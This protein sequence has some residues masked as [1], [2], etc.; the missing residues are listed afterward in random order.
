MR[1]R[2]HLEQ[3]QEQ[4]LVSGWCWDESHPDRAVGLVILVDGEPVGTTV[5][6]MFRADLEQA[7]IGN[8][9]HAFTYLLPWDRIA[10]KSV[11]TIS[12]IDDAT[13]ERLDSSVIFRRSIVQPVEERLH[14]LER[15]IR[16]LTARLDETAQQAQYDAA[17]MGGVFATIGMFFTRLSE[18]APD[19]AP[20]EFVTS[21]SGL[22]EHT[23]GRLTPFSLRMAAK[24]VMTICIHSA[25]TL[26][27]IYGCLHAIHVAGL[28]TEAEIVLIDDGKS[29]QAMLLPT[30]VQNLRYWHL[31]PGQSLLEARNRIVLTAGR[32]FA[33]FFSAATRVTQD[34]LPRILSTFEHQS[35]CAIVGAKIVRL[36]DTIE[37][38][39]LLPDQAGRLA[40]FAYAEHARTPRCDRLTP[41]AAVIDVAMAVRGE[42]FAE[43]G[44][45]DTGFTRLR[46]A[47]IDLCIRCWDNGHSVFYQPS[48]PLGW[49]DE[50]RLAATAHNVLDPDTAQLLAHRWR[51]SP[52]HAWPSTVG[53]ALLLDGPQEQQDP[54]APDLLQTACALQR[55]GYGLTFGVPGVLNGEEPRG[56]ALRNIGVEV[57]R[58][59]FHSSVAAAI[60]NSADTYDLI[61]V[62]G[63]ASMGLSPEALR[64]LTPGSKIVLALD[65]ETE[66]AAALESESPVSKARTKKIL[67]DIDAS[68]YVLAQTSTH[69]AS[70]RELSKGKVRQLGRRIRLGY[71]ERSGIWLA[72][73]RNTA[74]RQWF[75]KSILPHIRKYLPEVHI[76][77]IRDHD[78]NVDATPDVIWH[79]ASDAIGLL[80]TMRLAVAPVR[81]EGAELVDIMGC[82]TRGLPV[83][84]TTVAFPAERPPPGLLLVRANGHEIAQQVVSIYGNETAWRL[85]ADG[86]DT[87]DTEV[88]ETS[89]GS[90][91]QHSMENYREVVRQLGLPSG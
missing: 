80:Q 70:L 72:A 26:Q 79:D 5:A 83:V 50:V 55:L 47:S 87:E 10:S 32:R 43:L 11:T 89:Q 82:I 12:L 71:A 86:I 1:P 41:V 15:Q 22:L 75:G 90:L 88:F 34:W 2:S 68:D 33:A 69:M 60:Q 40:D 14:D 65:A 63:R 78:V 53:R 29:D 4:G 48:C 85:I 42:V 39:G 73:S 52:R 28:D 54:A 23:Q 56:F 77:A 49:S 7:G 62:T 46:G 25:G 64:S 61:Y 13:G 19:A 37:V 45:F 51:T 81:Q 76:H 18:I 84:A 67:A 66:A 16:L 44:G 9:H 3:V 35:Q 38:S 91:Y 20:T 24:P 58:A 57:L 6:D 8:G 21:L 31:Q 30:L 59:P 17:A 36:D 74:S 27:G